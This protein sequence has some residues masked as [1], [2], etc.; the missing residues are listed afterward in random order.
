MVS[1]FASHW[2][3]WPWFYETVMTNKL[4]LI[5]FKWPLC[6]HLPHP[7]HLGGF[8]VHTIVMGS[9]KG[10]A[11]VHGT[12]SPG[13]LSTC[14]LQ[15]QKLPLKPNSWVH[16]TVSFARILHHAQTSSVPHLRGTPSKM[17]CNALNLLFSCLRLPGT[18]ISSRGYHSWLQCL[19]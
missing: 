17:G 5:K 1:F 7:H 19:S 10:S 14:S 4:H 6:T 9:I 18:N 2:C 13:L 12:Q 16:I 8:G 3:P 15:Q 11:S